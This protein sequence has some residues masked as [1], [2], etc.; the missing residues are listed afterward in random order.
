MLCENIVPFG[1]VV[2]ME[3]FWQPEGLSDPH[4]YQ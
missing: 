3:M 2:P 4:G 1:T